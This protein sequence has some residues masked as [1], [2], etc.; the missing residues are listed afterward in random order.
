[1]FFCPKCSDGV[2]GKEWASRLMAYWLVLE[3][4][5]YPPRF[6]IVFTEDRAKS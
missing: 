1:M 6:C 2:M 4:G 5:G 3:M